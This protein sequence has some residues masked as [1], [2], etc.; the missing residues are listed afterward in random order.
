MANL[1]T[2]LAFLFIALLVF[3]P[4][5]ERFAPRAS[6][7]QQSKISRWILPLVGL[8]LVV[9]LFKSFMS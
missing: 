3:V 9:A 4:L 8:S 7:E 1:V 2:I 6:P 5:I